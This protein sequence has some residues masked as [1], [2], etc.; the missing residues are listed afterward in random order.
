MGAPIAKSIPLM[1]VWT[2]KLAA[3]T[4]KALATRSAQSVLMVST[5]LPLAQLA[6]IP[7]VAS[8]VVLAVTDKWKS[9]LARMIKIE[10]VDV[11]LERPRAQTELNV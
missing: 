4:Q 1:F 8:A 10:S 3:S 2:R 7:S 9:E 5:S 11:F 6:F